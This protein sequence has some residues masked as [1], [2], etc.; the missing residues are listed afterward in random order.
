MVTTSRVEFVKQL[1]FLTDRQMSLLQFLHSYLRDHRYMP[2]RR[3]VANFL[4][5]KSD[6]A[7]PYL[8]ALEK[9]GYLKRNGERVRRN[10]ELTP[11]AYEKLELES[12]ND[13]EK[14]TVN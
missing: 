13:F 11:T 12:E 9:K 5:L 8:V 3:E 1:P 7:T 10:L 14:G 2:T 6:N 4:E